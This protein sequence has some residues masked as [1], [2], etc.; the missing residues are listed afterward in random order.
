MRERFVLPREFERMIVNPRIGA[1]PAYNAGL[2]ASEFERLYGRAP[3]AKLDSNE[4]AFGASDL[5]IEAGKR[6]LAT[7]ALYPDGNGTALR[8]ALAEQT[9]VPME[10]IVLGNGS[11]ELIYACFAAVLEPGDHVLTVAPGFGL[12]NL[13]AQRLG[14]D[15][16][17]VNY[18][19][20]WALPVDELVQAL[21]EA[22]K[23]FAIAS[24]SN[25]MGVAM[26]LEEIEVLLRASSPDTL[27][28]LDEAYF[29]YHPLANLDLLKASGCNW[30]SLRTFSKAYALAG[31][32]IGY[33][34]CSSSQLREAMRHTT[35]PFNAN[36]VSQAMALASLQDTAHLQRT[37][38]LTHRA[39]AAFYQELTAR[40][41]QPAPSVANALFFEISSPALDAA[42][43]LR[44]EGILI[45]PWKE[46]GFEKFL[47]VS[48]GTE[49]DNKAFIEAIERL[50]LEPS[51]TATGA[52]APQNVQHGE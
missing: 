29:E 28:L 31:L 45:K 48:I 4:T 30:L 37:I 23:I 1:M 20:D 21:G 38:D 26:S 40:G 44:G 51:Q 24:P 19:S 27:F 6:A 33:G 7:P 3:V 42:D 25:P 13:A 18:G 16:R 49:Q 10:Q 36:S 32:R 8:Q 5:A 52:S 14:N 47:R 41:F 22:P 50:G 9:R 43:A 12:H 15:V 34:L 17:T 39:R 35:T 46:P 11:E 2:A